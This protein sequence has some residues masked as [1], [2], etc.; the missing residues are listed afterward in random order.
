MDRVAHLPRRLR[1]RCR[2]SRFSWAAGNRSDAAHHQ[3]QSVG[4]F[5]SAAHFAS[6]IA[7]EDPRVQSRREFLEDERRG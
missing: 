5:A 7:A 6:D 3:F 4:S 1:R 2:G